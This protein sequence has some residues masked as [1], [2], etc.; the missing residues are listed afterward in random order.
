[1]ELAVVRDRGRG[2][3]DARVENGSLEVSLARAW[4]RVCERVQTYQPDFAVLVA[5]KMPRIIEAL[6]LNLGGQVICVSDQALPFVGTQLANARVAIVDDIWNVGTTMLR[7]R[8]RVLQSGAREVRLFALGTR[9]EAKTAEAGV[10]LGN[11]GSLSDRNYRLLV[12]SVPRLLR[13][14]PKPYDAD[15]PLIPCVLRA[16]FSTWEQSWA[17]LQS[18][19]GEAAHATI[20][21][22]QLTNGLPRASITLRHEWGWTIKV[23]L[24]FDF[25]QRICNVVPMALA[26]TLPLENDYPTGSASFRV[27]SLLAGLSHVQSGRQLE[28]ER[29]DG[30]GRATAYCDSLLF[31]E[32]VTHALNGLLQRSSLAPFSLQEFGSEFGPAA[33]HECEA[34]LGATLPQ[35][36]HNMVEAFMRRRAVLVSEQPSHPSVISNEQVTARA[37]LYAEQSQPLRK[38]LDALL[39]DLA[40][41]VGAD[42]PDKY[43]LCSPFTRDEI[44]TDPYKRLRIGFTYGELLEFVRANQGEF[45]A[46]RHPNLELAFSALVDWFIDTGAMVP[47][48]SFQGSS[49]VRIYRKGEANPTYDEEYLRFQLALKQLPTKD[50]K[51][52]VEKGSTRLSKIAAIMSMGVAPATHLRPGAFERGT[53]AMLGK[54]VIER[55]DAEVTIMLHRLGLWLKDHEAQGS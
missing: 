52:L 25:R 44:A 42:D 49:C 2:R 39:Q 23:R 31:V 11:V 48:I 47:T 53:V 10:Y 12:N 26:P 9:D 38:I 35:P 16:P 20:D 54:T 3:D 34:L 32:D 15:F 22:E 30:L 29:R 7:A 13:S 45:S 14:V 17:W 40:R 51:Y 43:S 27:F 19:F 5:R 33:L 55:S 24:Y 46:A 8:D 21:Q 28:Y 4:Q 6:N 50:R 1:M 41:A 37:K 18:R 36:S